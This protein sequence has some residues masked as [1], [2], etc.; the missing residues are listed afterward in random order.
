MIK[1]N[2][3]PYCFIIWGYSDSGKDTIFELLQKHIPNLQNIKW[4]APAK[5]ILE[6]WLQI[7]VGSLDDKDFRKNTKVKNTVTRELES[8]TYDD[9]IVESFH[10]WEHLTPGGWLTVGHV[11]DQLLTNY[12]GKDSGFNIAFTDTRKPIELEAIKTKLAAH[13]NL[14]FINVV[15]RGEQKSSDKSLTVEDFMF[16]DNM[17]WVFNT[18]DV[19]LDELDFKV[20]RILNNLNEVV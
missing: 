6:E 10:A 11:V 20:K 5:R 14:V 4:V 18:I 17:Y 16:I 8:R 9:L 15:G 19:T 3:K 13:Y 2:K 12:I 7:P 1:R